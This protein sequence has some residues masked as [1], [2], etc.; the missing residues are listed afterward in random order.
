MGRGFKFQVSG[1]RLV[2]GGLLLAVLIVVNAQWHFDRMCATVFSSGAY[3]K[4]DG[5]YCEVSLQGVEFRLDELLE[6]HARAREQLECM[7]ANLDKDFMCDPRWM[8]VLDE[9]N[10]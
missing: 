5:V 10:G 1:L 3:F 7:I 9:D 8:P 4:W 2:V 6:R